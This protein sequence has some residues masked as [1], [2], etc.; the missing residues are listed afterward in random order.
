MELAYAVRQ[1][2]LYIT[3]S[4]DMDDYSVP[5]MRRTADTLIEQHATADKVIFNLAAVQF[6]DSTGIGFLIGR[7]KKCKRFMLPLFIQSP[8]PAADKVLSLSGVYSLI[9]KL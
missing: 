5:A 8:T 7:Y 4:G 3:L 6:M 2:A 9:P 1:N